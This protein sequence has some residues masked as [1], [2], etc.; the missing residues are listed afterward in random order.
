MWNKNTSPQRKQGK[1]I[2][3]TFRIHSSPSLARR[4]N[5]ITV[6]QHHQEPMANFGDARARPF[7]PP[8]PNPLAFFLT[9]T[10]YGTWLSGDERG[11][12]LPGKGIQVPDPIRK[13]AA[14]ARMTDTECTLDSEQRGLVK[15]T[16]IDHCVI[17][18]WE[19]YAVNCRKNHVHVVVSADRK[20]EDVRDQFKAWCTRKLKALQKSR[21]EQPREK[22]WTEKGS[23]RYIGDKENLEAAIHYVL[24]LQ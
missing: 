21:N 2:R 8:M 17:R 9:W 10:T 19:L 16:I 15:A 12:I 6:G 5:I 7:E 23:Q 24:E 1:I 13:R 4:T 18:R 11:W 3:E 22:W 20:P 14:K